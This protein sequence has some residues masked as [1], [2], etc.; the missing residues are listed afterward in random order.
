M[1]LKHFP[2][3]CIYIPN[4]FPANSKGSVINR[5]SQPIAI[6]PEAIKTLNVSNHC[7][8]LKLSL[9]MRSAIMPT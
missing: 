4:G 1:R 5:Q 6:L 7:L 3:I 2:E 9:P 8:V